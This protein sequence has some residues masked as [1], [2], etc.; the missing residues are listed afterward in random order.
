MSTEVLMPL[1]GEGV[2]EATVISWL[3]KPGD[4]VEK[5]E[6]LL[7]VST[8]K[9]DTEIP[10]PSDGFL[11]ATLAGEGDVIEVDQ[12]IAHIGA[13]ADE[14]IT[15]SA[16]SKKS[17][18]KAG[19]SSGAK[20][21]G[22]PHG[23][24]AATSNIPSTGG[25][26]S[27]VPMETAGAV[28]SSPLVR[29]MARDHG[30]DLRL[31]RGTGQH[32]RITKDDL[33]RFMSG[34]DSSRIPVIAGGS[35]EASVQSAF[36]PDDQLFGQKTKV[37][38]GTE[39]LEGV[40]VERQTM[41]KMRKVIAE[42][43]LRSVRVSPHV[44]TMI[45]IDLTNV[46]KYRAENQGSF[47]KDNGF[48]LT[49]TP[50]FIEA[51]VDAIKKDPMLNCSVDGYDVLMKKDINIGCAVAID[52]GLIVPVIKKSQEMNLSG[53][54]SS[55]N[56]LATR[57]RSKKLQPSEV[58]G[59]TFSITNPGMFG[60][61]A[62]TPIINQPQVAIMSVGSIVKRPVVIEN[63]EIAIRSMCTL[64]ITFDHRVVDGEGGAKFLA[65]V[66]NYLE[67]YK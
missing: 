50:F 12:V 51:A 23:N 35:G 14:K 43:M 13:T 57:A 31:V 22:M 59:G 25:F 61:L 18:K 53:L 27:P 60:C 62:S 19:A 56:D 24:T 40:I 29:N 33:E 64:G 48:K 42:H 67:N 55:L 26:S 41:P 8:D 30:I 47:T 6:P 36:S 32:G 34:A 9:V 39:T 7:E 10:A 65:N 11:L 5:D 21:S 1:M 3:K 63:D 54:A 4:K 44:T 38:D 52:D 45:E 28:R 49:F 15:E 20:A 2:N 58:T 17:S 37:K 66:K 46:V 16:A